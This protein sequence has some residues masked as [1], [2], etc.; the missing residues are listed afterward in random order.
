MR[1]AAPKPGDA[2]PS[3]PAAELARLR[4]MLASKEEENSA[5]MD[6][7]KQLQAQLREAVQRAD[8]ADAAAAAA[9]EKT[10]ALE[11]DLGEASIA[12]EDLAR[13]LGARD[14]DALR[15]DKE[16]SQAKKAAAQA[17]A[18]AGE[19]A[20]YARDESTGLV[21]AEA[22][23]AAAELRAEKLAAAAEVRYRR[24]VCGAVCGVET[25]R[26]V[27]GGARHTGPCS[28]LF[29]FQAKLKRRPLLL[30]APQEASLHQAYLESKVKD[31]Q[32]ENAALRGRA[33]E[34][35]VQVSSTLTSLTELEHGGPAARRARADG[36]AS[37]QIEYLTQQVASR[38]RQLA[39]KD[40][41][42][43]ALKLAREDL[44]RRVDT[45]AG[46]GG[47]TKLLADAERDAAEAVEAAREALSRARRERD[48]LGVALERVAG[49]GAVTAALADVGSGAG[50]AM[51][52]AS[53]HHHHH[54][55][56]NDAKSSGASAT[57]SSVAE[58]AA[59]ERAD[60]A[61]AQCDVLRRERAELRR[62]V[63]ELEV[64]CDPK[65]PLK[66][67]Q[68]DSA[69]LAATRR[70]DVAERQLAAVKADREDLRARLEEAEKHA[71]GGSRAADGEVDKPMAAIREELSG[72]HARVVDAMAK[73]KDRE[74]VLVKVL[75]RTHGLTGG[76]TS[77]SVAAAAALGAAAAVGSTSGEGKRRGGL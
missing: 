74:T 20:A 35:E 68:T 50:G 4:R 40:R 62:R 70:A 31:L 18:A 39:A 55:G 59:L 17:A 47:Y 72:A 7:Q 34:L 38:D 57:S 54:H 29:A 43:A 41:Q 2:G 5:I 32:G 14:D 52:A 51:A 8:A 73:L 26:R 23:A 25:R 69:L 49:T 37:Q 28:L 63:A 27:G 61:L 16:L 56:A 30:P 45:S 65:L 21:Q 58:R 1:G 48:A 6:L 42:L 19:A 11:R 12:V 76:A 46:P 15:L 33:R 77:A 75:A 10:A 71:G 60:E 13:Q 3:D 67:S 36:V 66:V 24:C 64:L 44:Q 53:A 9:K 22:R